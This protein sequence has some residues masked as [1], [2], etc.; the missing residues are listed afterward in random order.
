MISLYLHFLFYSLK[1]SLGRAFGKKFKDELKSLDSDP[2]R[3]KVSAPIP[4]QHQSLTSLNLDSD[5]VK[6]GFCPPEERKDFCLPEAMLEYLKSNASPASCKSGTSSTVGSTSASPVIL[7]GN[8]SPLSYRSNIDNLSPPVLRRNAGNR[9]PVGNVGSRNHMGSLSPPGARGNVGNIYLNHGDISPPGYRVNLTNMSPLCHRRNTGNM[10]PPTN[11]G[12]HGVLPPTTST[13]ES[14][15]AFR[16]DPSKTD[17][18]EIR[19]AKRKALA[20]SD[21]TLYKSALSEMMSPDHSSLPQKAD[22]AADVTETLDQPSKS[23]ETTSSSQETLTDHTEE[24]TVDHIDPATEAAPV[25]AT[26]D[27]PSPSESSPLPTRVSSRK[28]KS[29][30]TGHSKVEGP[31]VS[32]DLPTSVSLRKPP[33]QRTVSV[34]TTVRVAAPESRTAEERMIDNLSLLGKRASL[35]EAF[36]QT[37]SV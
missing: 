22:I 35:K 25:P 36:P 34:D 4:L 30:K 2:S 32:F 27:L 11:R 15:V 23:G 37:T 33:L 28:L 12:N 13:P 7:R 18:N 9:S 8:A 16:S 17:F 1:G 26:R 21:Q 14:P 24:A 5:L 29:S 10:C 20:Y 31:S 19:S 3:R 6:K